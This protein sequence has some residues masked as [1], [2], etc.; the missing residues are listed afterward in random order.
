MAVS[1]GR[2]AFLRNANFLSAV[3]F[4]VSLGDKGCASEG[5]DNVKKR[6]GLGLSSAK[7]EKQT[8]DTLQINFLCGIYLSYAVS[9]F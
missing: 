9:F 7:P 2:A 4:G 3:N 8:W 1:D 5:Q 6:S